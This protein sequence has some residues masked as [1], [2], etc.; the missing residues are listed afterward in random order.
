MAAT[1]VASIYE[2]V[3]L[4][5]RELRGASGDRAL[6]PLVTVSRFVGS[7]ALDV[8]WETQE[9]LAPL[10][11]VL[12]HVVILNPDK[13][14]IDIPTQNG[15]VE[16]KTRVITSTRLLCRG[17]PESAKRVI[18]TRGWAR[19]Q[20][21]AARIKIIDNTQTPGLVNEGALPLTLDP[22]LARAAARYGV[23]LPR[24]HTMHIPLRLGAF[25]YRF[26]LGVNSD[27]GD[28]GSP[29]VSLYLAGRRKCIANLYP[30]TNVVSIAIA[31]DRQL[32]HLAIL[33]GLP[34]LET[35]SLH[36]VDCI[37]TTTEVAVAPGFRALKYLR[38][39]G[40]W[41]LFKTAFLLRKLSS[42]PLALKGIIFYGWTDYRDRRSKEENACDMHAAIREV[43][44]R[45]TLKRLVIPTPAV[46]R[47]DARKW[48]S[49]LLPFPNIDMVVVRVMSVH[50]KLKTQSILELM[51]AAWPQLTTLIF[52]TP[53][54]DKHNLDAPRPLSGYLSSLAPLA[55]HFPRLRLAEFQDLDTTHVPQA[56]SVDDERRISG[57]D[58]WLYLPMNTRRRNTIELIN[59]Y[60]ASLVPLNTPLHI[61]A[62][63]AIWQ[64]KRRNVEGQYCLKEPSSPPSQGLRW[65]EDW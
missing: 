59:W 15:P 58:L 52:R 18:S 62:W 46:G 20:L 10:F 64:T 33:R 24:L 61:D 23:L 21:Y 34:A 19:M 1:H 39:R 11:C 41:N 26:R 31:I 63:W 57:R 50:T 37:I 51:G 29:M 8:L 6:V 49:D 35:L 43:C 44:D 42:R 45:D 55:T 2:L 5:A 22:R 36:D 56:L 25:F 30:L 32:A 4:I 13:W 12:R 47:W 3:D 16:L 65:I 17:P 60:L 14:T 48:L 28:L 9:D 27:T 54:I 7:V 38:I 40:P 53:P